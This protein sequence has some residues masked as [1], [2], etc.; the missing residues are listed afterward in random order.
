[1][2]D[3]A[4]ANLNPGLGATR[5]SIRGSLEIIKGVVI[6]SEPQR[7]NAAAIPHLSQ[8]LGLIARFLWSELIE[9][10]QFPATKSRD[11]RNSKCQI[12]VLAVGYLHRD[13]PNDLAMHIEKR[14]AA[15]AMRNRRRHLD[16]PAEVRHLAHCGDDAI[17]D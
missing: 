2:F 6:V 16:D 8:S 13:D 3:F 1:M 11:P 7:I 17:T 5:I 12:N 15:V 10:H 9:R 4:I 14:A